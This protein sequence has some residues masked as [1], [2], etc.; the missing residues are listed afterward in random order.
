L[1]L[2]TSPELFELKVLVEAHDWHDVATLMASVDRALDPHQA[3]VS[4]QRR[5]SV[6]ANRLPA[7]HAQELLEFL[8]RG[9]TEVALPASQD[10]TLVS[11]DPSIVDVKEAPAR[12]SA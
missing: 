3:A 4:G 8:D 2:T 7:E 9:P 11:E 6:V 5:W 1:K 12:R 10:V